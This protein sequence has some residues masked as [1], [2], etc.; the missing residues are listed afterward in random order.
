MVLTVILAC[1]TQI[2][3]GQLGNF[4]PRI[5]KAVRAATLEKCNGDLEE[6]AN[7]NPGAELSP[8]SPNGAR[9]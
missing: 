1:A 8:A 9:I 5:S 2:K 4:F 6:A 3:L 7:S